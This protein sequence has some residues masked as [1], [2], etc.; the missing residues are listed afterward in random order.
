V[1]LTMLVRSMMTLFGP[2]LSRDVVLENLVATIGGALTV[3]RP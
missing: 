1:D 2:Y 3:V